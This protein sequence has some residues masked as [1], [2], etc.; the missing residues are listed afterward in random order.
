MFFLGGMVACRYANYFDDSES[1]DHEESQ[2]RGFPQRS[3]NVVPSHTRSTGVRP[4]LV[5]VSDKYWSYEKP[6]RLSRSGR[7]VKKLHLFLRQW[8]RNYSNYFCY[9]HLIAKRS[10][11]DSLVFVFRF[12][13]AS[14]WPDRLI[15]RLLYSFLFICCI[16]ITVVT[17][18]KERALVKYLKIDLK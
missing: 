11:H 14:T 4:R 10:P 15:F 1:R 12:S 9:Y 13:P 2:N 3:P 6:D 17:E 5:H 8:T 18:I 7:W 16:A